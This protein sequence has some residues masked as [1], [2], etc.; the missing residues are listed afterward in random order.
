[1][2]S[3]VKIVKLIEAC[4]RKP[5]SMLG[6]FLIYGLNIMSLYDLLVTVPWPAVVITVII[7]VMEWKLLVVPAINWL[8][9]QACRN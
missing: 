2:L 1:M 7:G 5:F 8:K 9:F 3:A 6:V 4:R